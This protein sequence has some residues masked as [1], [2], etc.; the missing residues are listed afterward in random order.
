[1]SKA[2]KAVGVF[3][4][5]GGV[6]GGAYS[7][8]LARSFLAVPGGLVS[9][10]ILVTVSSGSLIAGI[11]LLRSKRVGL[12]L[13]RAVQLVQVPVVSI[14]PVFYYLGLGGF[15]GVG[16]SATPLETGGFHLSAFFQWGL[17]ADFMAALA[18][19]LPEEY[20][21]INVFA[22]VMLLILFTRAKAL[23]HSAK[24]A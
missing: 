23:S 2:L 7:G 4:I 20:F 24:S 6:I 8:L 10:A 1:M 14:V 11:L 9:L 22:A 3:E 15:L 18:S 16:S 5:I 12:L 21:A 17:G 13:S 19:E